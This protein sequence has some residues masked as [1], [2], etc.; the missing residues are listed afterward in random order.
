MVELAYSCG[1]LRTIRKF[2][3]GISRIELWARLI[4]C[5]SF[6]VEVF[7]LFVRVRKECWFSLTPKCEWLI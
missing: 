1:I 3:R 6:V 4:I 7:G 2:N 5:C